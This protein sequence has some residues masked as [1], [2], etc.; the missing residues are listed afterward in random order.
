LLG[1]EVI[2]VDYDS[3]VDD[4]VDQLERIG[5]LYITPRLDAE[6]GTDHARVLLFGGVLGTRVVIRNVDQN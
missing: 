5:H 3:A 6:E 1:L 2:G 4:V